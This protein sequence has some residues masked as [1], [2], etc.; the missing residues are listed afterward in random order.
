MNKK[1]ELCIDCNVY[2]CSGKDCHKPNIDTVFI[3]N[4][5]DDCFEP[6]ENGIGGFTGRI[7]IYNF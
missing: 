4:I 3:C 6:C 2:E 5:T 1:C 7:P